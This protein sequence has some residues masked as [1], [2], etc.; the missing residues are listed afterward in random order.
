LDTQTPTLVPLT[1]CVIDNAKQIALPSAQRLR[2][3]R[4]SLLRSAGDEKSSMVLMGNS[5]RKE[6]L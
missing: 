3:G 1:S 6:I 2:K 4:S 5:L